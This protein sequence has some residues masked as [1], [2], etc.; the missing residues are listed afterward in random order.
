MTDKELYI[1]W[2]QDRSASFKTHDKQLAY[3]VRKSSETNCYD[4]NGN[5][6]QE[7]IDFCDK[8]Y[9]DNCTIEI[10]KEK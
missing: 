1:V 5:K 10:V 9:N 7:A 6:V 2:N 3:E 4:S 8:W